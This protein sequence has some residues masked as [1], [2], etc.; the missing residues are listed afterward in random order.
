MPYTTETDLNGLVQAVLFGNQI[1]SIVLDEKISVSQVRKKKF[2]RE[3]DSKNYK[4]Y[5]LYYPVGNGRFDINKTI[6]DLKW[7][8]EKEI[9]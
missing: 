9:S 2:E 6:E 3:I 7:I 4:I 8:I 1:S 5:S